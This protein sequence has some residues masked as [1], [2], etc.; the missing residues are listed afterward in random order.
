VVEGRRQSEVVSSVFQISPPI[1]APASG[2]TQNSQSW[3]EGVGGGDEATPVDAP[4]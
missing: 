2:A 1:A 4:G 3:C